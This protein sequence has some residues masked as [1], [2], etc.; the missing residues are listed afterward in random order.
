LPERAR[1]AILN[2]FGRSLGDSIIGIQALAVALETGALPG[3]PVLFR[4]PGLSP[5]VQGAYAAAAGLAEVRTLPWDDATPDRPFASAAGFG[6]VIDLR[7]FA[8]DPAFR[9]VAMIDFFLRRLGLDPARVPPARRRNAWLRP[10]LPAPPRPDLPP[11]YV[12]VCPRTSMALR[13][14]PDAVHAAILDALAGAGVPVATQGE[15]RQGVSAA[16]TAAGFADLCGLVANARAVVS[17][18]T[19]IPHLADAYGVACLAFFTTHR[20]A[21][22]VRDYPLC[23]SIHLPADLPPALEFSR[24]P[25]D[26]VAARAAWR[27][28]TDDQTLLRAAIL[29]LLGRRPD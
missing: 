23:Q 1:F 17:A 28:A 4:L 15:P 22:R 12:L 3:N 19:A 21:W 24:G 27:A 2:G 20:P 9:G 11:G 26:E 25:A 8:F 29:G 13:D 7:D 5:I 6:R 10:R 18:D 14:M 16:P